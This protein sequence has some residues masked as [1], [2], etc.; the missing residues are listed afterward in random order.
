MVDWREEF[1]SARWHFDVAVRMIETYD[2]YRE[3]RILVG[4]IREAAK[5][6]GKLVRAFL[7]REGIRG[8]VKTFVDVVGPKYLSKEKIENLVRILEVERGQ[9]VSRVEFS[10]GENILMEIEGKWRILRVSRLREFVDSLGEVIRDFP[11]S[12]KR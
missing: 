9:R 2:G 7:I 8:N 1:Y 6:A 11:A 5:C 3:K 4:V 12:I 10:K